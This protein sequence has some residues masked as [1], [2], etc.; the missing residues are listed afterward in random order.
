M[1]HT[2]YSDGRTR[3]ALASIV[4]EGDADEAEP[5]IR[6]LGLVLVIGPQPTPTSPSP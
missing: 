4:Y 5:A 1:D 2:A 6:L 3:I